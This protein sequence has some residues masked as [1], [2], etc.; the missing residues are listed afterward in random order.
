LV[1]HLRI[2]ASVLWVGGLWVGV[3]VVGCGGG[4]DG[5]R[6]ATVGVDAPSQSSDGGACVDESDCDDGNE[7]TDD[8]CR[9]DGACHNPPV[10]NGAPCLDGAGECFDGECH[11]ACV[12]EDCAPEGFPDCV[13]GRCNADLNVCEYILD[14]D[15]CEDT[16]DECTRNVCHMVDGCQP[17]DADDDT[18]CDAGMGPGS[19]ACQAGVCVA[20]EG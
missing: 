2:V 15:T 9:E 4:S 10:T 19:G 5:E 17:E 8:V 12:D 20:L 18:P 11:G 14:S 3:G 1:L 13:V 6:D 7:C 16:G